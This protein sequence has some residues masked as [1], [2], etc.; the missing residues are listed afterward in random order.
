M[1]KNKLKIRYA[2]KEDV[3]LIQELLHKSWVD[4]Y[5]N[6]KLGI[7]KELIDQKFIY[8]PEDIKRRQEELVEGPGYWV[9]EI[10]NVMV[11][12]VRAKKH[13][14]GSG[15]LRAIYLHPDYIGMGIGAELMKTALDWLKDCSKVLVK[16][17]SYNERAISFYKK[18]GFENP[19]EVESYPLNE[20]VALPQVVLEKVNKKF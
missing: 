16:C 14:D 7:T 10:D 13:E 15:E 4:T 2:R 6:E 18:F 19:K 8:D 5:V 20:N 12:F 17:A 3:P 9:A 1:E 11:G